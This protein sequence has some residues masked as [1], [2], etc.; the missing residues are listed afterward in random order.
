MEAV[1]GMAE[2]R[3]GDSAILVLQNENGC[4]MMGVV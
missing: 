3:V 1:V 2:K 4:G